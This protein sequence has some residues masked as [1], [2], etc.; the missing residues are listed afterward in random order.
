MAIRPDSVNARRALVVGISSF[1]GELNPLPGHH[2]RSLGAALASLGC[3]TEIAEDCSASEL[4]HLLDSAVDA[5]VEVVHLLSH[6]DWRRSD[7]LLIAGEGATGSDDRRDWVDIR[8]WLSD[9]SESKG[10]PVLLTVDTCFAGDAAHFTWLAGGSREVYVLAAAEPGTLA[11]GARFTRAVS[12]VLNR[13]ANGDTLEAHPS[14]EFIPLGLVKSAVALEL[15]ELCRKSGTV[16]QRLVSSRHELDQHVHSLFRNPAYPG[17]DWNEEL[18]ALASA[19]PALADSVDPVMGGLHFLTRASG[20]SPDQTTTV[21]HFVGRRAE[22][23]R[24]SQW[25]DDRHPGE[26]LRVVIGSP[27]MGKSALLGVLVCTVHPDLQPFSDHIESRIDAELKPD[28]AR[29][30]EVAAVNAR[31]RDIGELVSSLARQL[32]ATAAVRA[33]AEL[34]EHLRSLPSAPLIVLDALDEAV[35]PREIQLR[36]LVPLASEPGLCRLIV[37]VR[38]EARFGPIFDLASDY[39]LIDLDRVEIGELRRD[40]EAYV[41]S[42]L[43]DYA[44]P[45]RA[46]R[47]FAET[48]AAAVTPA[49]DEGHR[50]IGPFLLAHLHTHRVAATTPR[51]AESDDMLAAAGSAPRSVRDAFEQFVF[52]PAIDPAVKAMLVALAHAQGVGMPIRLVEA[53]A[54]RL[55]PDLS[56][57][58]QRSLNSVLVEQARFYL[59]TDID[60]DGAVVYALFHQSLQDYLRT[61]KYSPS[62]SR[63]AAD[64]AFD[65][66]LAEVGYGDHVRPDWEN[67]ANS[68]IRLHLGQHAIAAGRFDELAGDPDFLANADCRRLLRD[69]R[70]AQSAEAQMAATVY[71]QSHQYHQTVPPSR[72]AQRLAL[73]AARVGAAGLRDRV[74]ST[75][76]ATVVTRWSTGS[77]AEPRLLDILEVPN[78]A[79]AAMT[80]AMVGER[81]VVIS[82]GAGVVHVWDVGTGEV[83]QSISS[84]GRSD[85]VA[86]A[87]IGEDSLL[88]ADGGAP[89]VWNLST[90][91]VQYRL[92]RIDGPMLDAA[93]VLANGTATAVVVE[94][95]GRARVWN[96]ADATSV[97]ELAAGGP[98]FLSVVCTTMGERAVAVTGD[99]RGMVRIWDLATGT[100]VTTLSQRTGAVLTLCCRKFGA[101]LILAAGDAEGTV[102]IWDFAA[103]QKMGAFRHGSRSVTALALTLVNG[104]VCV[105]SSS[106][107]RFVRIWDATTG[108]LTYELSGHRAPVAAITSSA[109][110]GQEVIVSAAQ[111]RTMRVWNL[112]GSPPPDR[113]ASIFGTLSAL[114]ASAGELVIAGGTAGVIRVM[115][116]A[117]G[118]HVDIFE[119]HVG[120]EVLCMTIASLTGQP[121]VVSGDDRG[122]ICVWDLTSRSPIRQQQTD[123]PAV[124]QIASTLIMGRPAVV[125]GNDPVHLEVLDVETGQSVRSL[126]N[127]DWM[128]EYEYEIDRGGDPTLPPV[129]RCASLACLDTEDRHVVAA[130]SDPTGLWDMNTGATVRSDLV[131]SYL[132]VDFSRLEE[133]DVSVFADHHSITVT[134][135]GAREPARSFTTISAGELLGAVCAYLDGLPVVVTRHEP[136]SVWLWDLAT[137]EPRGS[138]HLPA[139]VTGVVVNLDTVFVCYGADVA[140]LHIPGIGG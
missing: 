73:D 78:G 75:L 109:R 91:A 49:V 106:F 5:D 127:Q 123:L 34:F 63:S 87:Q 68:Y 25:I 28:R 24:L 31:N 54:K 82:S 124:R 10:K 26:G 101:Q 65:V 4:T 19:E 102:R 17:G 103:G 130:C 56:Q 137:G 51:P 129:G 98:R 45:T 74:A 97:Y 86:W 35:D 96:L 29:P 47:A 52:S 15:G 41:T 1:G 21:C 113:G 139:K 42:L 16:P 70:H 138:H 2:V 131:T 79:C 110:Y 105:A 126:I 69:L 134:A 32:R 23:R 111:D 128:D 93:L 59:R 81:P 3:D 132:A 44:W 30:G 43:R 71:R 48:V 122:C 104:R 20:G 80:S 114:A 76:G 119:G 72:R 118:R 100:A 58:T 115:D 8:T 90:G 84:P 12:N 50:D 95:S 22:L 39:G 37:G 36:L 57:R 120:G 18:L 33:P 99:S 94:V 112:S 117:S 136:P 88:L 133:V 64:I 83:E 13:L 121:V 125:I 9:L 7:R 89:Q 92:P 53:I 38:H 67:R 77:D 140:A 11:F 85:V 108:V 14:L 60:D 135:I 66:L 40:V 6:G 116:S 27:G 61:V 62:I 55:D 46:A 107:D